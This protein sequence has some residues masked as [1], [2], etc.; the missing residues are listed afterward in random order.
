MHSVPRRRGRP[1]LRVLAALVGLTALSALAPLD[2]TTASAASL[3]PGAALRAP[4]VSRAT[5]E[6]AA[7]AEARKAGR[8]VEVL[9]R[10]S[11]SGQ[12]FA[13]P[14][15]RLT[16][17]F[18]PTAVRVKKADGGWAAV[19][20][21]L[22]AG[23][24]GTVRPRAAAAD[25]VFSGGGSG[26]LARMTKDGKRFALSWP[27]PL[28][29]PALKG[30]AA[31]YAEVLPGTDLVVRATPTGFSHLLIVKN[32]R[33]AANPALRTVR[34]GLRGS[35]GLT[36][37]ADA[38]GALT[39]KDAAG[40]AV[41][42]SAR[43]VMWD[44]PAEAGN[45]RPKGVEAVE[46]GA[47]RN[48]RAAIGSPPF[49][50]YQ[51]DPG[52]ARRARVGVKVT[53]RGA[54]AA[55]EVTPDRAMLT[56]P[57]ARFPLVIDPTF[58][59]RPMWDWN[60]FENQHTTTNYWGVQGTQIKVG[61]DGAREWRG[62]FRFWIDPVFGAEIRSARL[63]VAVSAA[64]SCDASTAMNL[65]TTS[66]TPQYATWSNSGWGGWM[67]S[68]FGCGDANGLYF[69]S[70]DAFR[71]KVQEAANNRWTGGIT[72]GVNTAS[73]GVY[74][75]LTP[76]ATRLVIEYNHAPS[77]PAVLGMVPA[78]P[79]ATGAERTYLT[80]SSPQFTAK[81]SDPNGDNVGGR[82]E[83]VRKSDGQVVYSDPPAGTNPALSVRSGDSLTW[84]PVPDGRLAAGVVYTYR[85]ATWDGLAWSG[86]T[87]PGCEF[88]IDLGEARTPLVTSP[89]DPSVCGEFGPP[90]GT[91][92]PVTFRPAP[93]D[94]GI[95][96]YRYGTRQGALTMSVA[97]GPDGTATVPVTQWTS[98]PT[99]LYV[100]AVHRSGQESTGTASFDVSAAYD[101]KSPSGRRGDA[102]G[103]GLAD[104]AAVFSDGSTQNSVY[105]WHASATGSYPPVGVE[106]NNGYAATAV[107]TVR[108]DFDGDGRTDVAVLRQE[109]GDRVTGWIYRSDGTSYE[110]P[111]AAALDT[112]GNPGWNLGGLKPVAGD[113]DGD[114]KA[115]L[116]VF[117]SHPSC[118]TKLW[119]FY[120]TG[121]A[122]AGSFGQPAWA[123]GVNGYCWDRVKPVVGDFDDAADGRQ[124]IA[125]F[126]RWDGN[127]DWSVDTFRQTGARG[128]LT[129][130][131][132]G[133]RDSGC[134]DWNRLKPV[135]GDFNGDGRDD[136]GHL[137]DAGANSTTFWTLTSTGNVGG[138]AF[139]PEVQRSSEALG[140][141]ALEPSAAD[142]DG[143]G[144]DEV[145]VV[146]RSSASR[147]VLWTL[148]SSDG[149]AFT[150]S[151]RWD[152]RVTA[153]LGVNG[154][155]ASL[156]GDSRA[157]TV[158][159]KA[160]GSLWGAPNI[161]GLHGAWGAERYSAG[162]STDPA[163]AFFPD[164][165]GDGKKEFVYL[166][167]DGVLRGYPNVDGLNDGYGTGRKVG[168]NFP[169]PARLRFADLDGDGRDD[170]VRIDA[171][172]AIQAWP[173]VRGIDGV[174]GTQR[175]VGSGWT[176][177]A[178]T[179]FADLNGDGRD[180]L[181]SI[182]GD[183][184]LRAFANRNGIDF[185]WAPSAI[186]GSGF[187]DPARAF[188]ADLDGD[189]RDEVVS[190]NGNGELWAW[191]NDDVLGTGGWGP[192]RLVSAGWTD[193]SRL[194]FA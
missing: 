62:I 137:Y 8:R 31:T 20:T 182:D 187:S 179:R 47:V 51:A 121:T 43:P 132:S 151:L 29:K 129:Q 60:L 26:P 114:G 5:P 36:T 91:V 138:V 95:V 106:V 46:G 119:T 145:V 73:A 83:V 93:G 156:S 120:S 186:V 177:P 94:T 133:A 69:P 192:S 48:D 125:L 74:K 171:D 144:P 135:V 126:Y 181:V 77:A 30:D 10:R 113:F 189:R 191:P 68:A 61:H 128:S 55:L 116:A 21:T 109:A 173:N 32:A 19:D 139:A 170:L 169:E 157:E 64:S 12:V 108:G 163:R 161:D 194:K 57:G 96:R 33:A 7:L 176:D 183:G 143:T 131:F 112:A 105:T 35:E 39:A 107:Q 152:G 45:G 97:A 56:D 18:A 164:L 149:T 1:P 85:A 184:R 130:G 165:D 178:R 50:T 188:F 90:M 147:T 141:G 174:W 118:Q 38:A 23:A 67:S 28:P 100:K 14:D 193:P 86:A 123:S 27:V 80:T 16:G 53:G 103:D 166:K 41:F 25:V 87:A 17:E 117:A 110:P 42:V 49:P 134:S 159:V 115:D 71:G 40:K 99:W 13:N 81:L 180:D 3:T 15:G 44:S 140:W 167:P 102:G 72:F 58:L 37:T 111:A 190:A 76:G 104:T 11:E 84:A 153:G 98:D 82:L 70:N 9:A 162:T 65:H 88:E 122:F 22:A 101:P 63:K 150:R 2:P 54:G 66:Q 124:E 52:G 127:C 136:L 155:R 78:K 158:R 6:G 89:C 4:A 59:E 142:T 160:D 175:Q 92:R 79:C 172:G 168:E 185:D 34:F 75:T 146:D 24:D 154:K 148:R